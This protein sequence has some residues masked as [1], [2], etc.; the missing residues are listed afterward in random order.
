MNNE[1]YINRL[2]ELIDDACE[3]RRLDINEF[4]D[5][6][7]ILLDRVKIKDSEGREHFP[8]RYATIE[9]ISQEIKDTKDFYILGEPGTEG[10]ERR[11]RDITNFK[12]QASIFS[13]RVIELFTDYLNPKQLTQLSKKFERKAFEKT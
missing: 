12:E 3:G 4:S 6:L 10:Y 1:Y 7:K 9:T 2:K 8:V 5:L 13:F 11:L